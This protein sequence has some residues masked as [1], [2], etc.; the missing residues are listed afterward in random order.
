[1]TQALGHETQRVDPT[2]KV[3]VHEWFKSVLQEQIPHFT[4]LGK[5]FGEKLF[6]LKSWERRSSSNVV[7]LDQLVN[8]GS[9]F[10]VAGVHAASWR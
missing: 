2:S 3:I 4:K 9:G 1:M 6:L 5:D 10:R 8:G 7:S